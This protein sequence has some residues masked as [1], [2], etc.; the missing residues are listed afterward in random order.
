MDSYL[1][2]YTAS[3]KI[4]S[5]T[6]QHR[7]LLKYHEGKVILNIKNTGMVQ[8]LSMDQEVMVPYLAQWA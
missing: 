4:F 3:A 8:C 2:R 6:W 5:D 1:V 7:E